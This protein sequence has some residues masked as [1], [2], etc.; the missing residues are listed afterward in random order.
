MVMSMVRILVTQVIDLSAVGDD[1]P[2]FTAG[3]GFDG[4]KGKTPGKR[5]EE[6]RGGKEWRL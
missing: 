5:S 6:R 1:A 4:I 3:N 2:A